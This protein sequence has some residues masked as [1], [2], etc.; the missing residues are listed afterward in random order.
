VLVVTGGSQ[1]GLQAMLTA[2]IHPKITAAVA[3]V[4][5]GCDQSGPDAGRSPGWPQW[6]FQAD[7]KDLSRVKQA[8]L[9]YDIVNFTPRIH[10]PIFVAAG[11]IDILC[12]PPGIIA[13]TNRISGPKE[14][15]VMPFGGHQD[16][17]EVCN[18]RVE[19]WFSILKQGKVPEIK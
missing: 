6:Y 19:E 1:G 7:G 3:V 16:R 13:A 14:V 2:A 15:M 11:L 18:A 12:P 4:P 8:S 17:H 9:Y 5:A 10:C